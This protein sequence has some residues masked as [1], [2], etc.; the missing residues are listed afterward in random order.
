MTNPFGRRSSGNPFGR[1]LNEFEGAERVGG[2][3]AAGLG[4][5]DS[6]L[7]GFSEELYGAGAGGLAALRGEDFGGAYTDAVGDARRR[8]AL[9]REQQGGAFLAGQLGGALVGGG[10]LSLAGRAALRGSSALSRVAGGT[11]WAGRMGLSA[12]SGGAGGAL[13]GAGSGDAGNRLE[14]AGQ[15]AGLGAIGGAAFSGLGSLVGP[16]IANAWRGMSPN[17]GAAQIMGQVLA[18]EGLTDEQFAARLGEHA[19][20]GRGGMVLDALGQSGTHAAMGAATRPSAGL[21]VLTEAMDARQ[22]AVGPRAQGEIWEQ[23]VGGAP[24]DVAQFILRMERVQR[25]EA[26]PLYAQAWQEIGRVNP[27]RMQ[28]TVGETMRRHPEIFGPARERAQ[29]MS[30]AE[31]GREIAD[32]SDPRTWHYLLMGAEREL[33]ARL[34]AASMGDLRGFAG[35]EAAIYSRAVHNFNRQVRAALGPTFR[36]AQDTYAGAASAQEAAELGY[37][38]ISQNLNTLTLGALVQRFTRMSAGEQQAFR[39]AAANKMQDMVANATREG[40]NRADILRGLIGTEGKRTMLS[41]IFGER[42]LETLLRRFDYDR[43]L[44]QNSVNTGIN[45]NSITSKAIA[46]SNQQQAVTGAPTTLGGVANRLLAPQLRDAAERSNEEVSTRL[47]TLMAMPADEAAARLA[48]PVRGGLLSRARQ[49]QRLSAQD[50]LFYDALARRND[51][52]DFRRNA[53]AESLLGTSGLYGG[54]T[55][56]PP[57]QQILGR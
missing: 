3:E 33:G 7:F 37:S 4:A 43:Q 15:Y 38:A 13:Y 27:A 16:H 25:S 53:F 14:M 32:P 18:R 2:W 41:R 49:Q 51:I 6:A 39:A 30:L 34:R 50:R 10:G 52:T 22:Q 48:R 46:A 29:R 42:G 45:V 35:S 19:A 8:T 12:L 9:A 40:A 5:A 44:L 21:R 28:A 56:Q 1:N 31:T 20:Q 57:A 11:N 17:R 54:V 24:E 26:A 55:V 36:R 47:L 23:L